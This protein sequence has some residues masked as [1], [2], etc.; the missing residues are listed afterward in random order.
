MSVTSRRTSRRTPAP[1][2]STPSTSS[3]ADSPAK[4]SPL[5]DE[6]QD[7]TEPVAGSSSTTCASFARYDLASSSWRTSQLSLLEG[8]DVY[9]GSWP[10]A[11]TMRNGTCCLR[12]PSAPRTSASASSS[13]LPTPSAS[14]Y[15]T[16][17][18]DSPGAKVRPSLPMMARH[19]MLPTPKA[20]DGERG[21]RGE[22]TSLVK[23]GHNGRRRDMLPTP[24]C[25]TP[26]WQRDRNGNVYP[27]L[28]GLARDGLLPTPTARLG[29]DRG[30]PSSDTAS[31]RYA[32]G[33][34]N[35]D[36]WVM[37]PTP[38]A[39]LAKECAAP[40]EFTL[41]TPTLTA[42]VLGPSP[43]VSLHP[44][45]VEWMMGFPLGWTDLDLD[46]AKIQTS[47]D[48]SHRGTE[49]DDSDR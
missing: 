26:T 31:K 40:A 25:N 24:T 15:G 33:R 43:G 41:N 17:Q 2:A 27:T 21:G 6:A 30:L 8:L 35:L 46:D 7:L 3:A 16:N 34:R 39:H 13:L 29:D 36:D 23:Y 5:R 37:L 28:H 22:L 47:P 20:S 18:T 4:T 1:G 19:G 45:F 44:R 49:G 10:R 38:T 12:R 9:S 32:Q 14:E 42:S 48:T 11:G